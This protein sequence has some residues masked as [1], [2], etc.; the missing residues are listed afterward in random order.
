MKKMATALATVLLTV[1]IG[2]SGCGSTSNNSV[3][4]DTNASTGVEAAGPI[5]A[6]DIKTALGSVDANQLDSIYFADVYASDDG[7]QVTIIGLWELVP[8]HGILDRCA[9]QIDIERDEKTGEAKVKNTDYALEPD[10]GDKEISDELQTALGKPS[11]E[12]YYKDI[13]KQ[14]IDAFSDTL[15]DP[16]SAHYS[17]IR[18]YQSKESGG[19]NDGKFTEGVLVDFDVNAKNRLGGYVG[20]EHYIFTVHDDGSIEQKDREPRYIGFDG[21]SDTFR[22]TF[23]PGDLGLE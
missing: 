2:L 1:A 6:S 16:Y 11:S 9:F 23:E 8:K 4:L 7:M 14:C 22:K 17:S 15:I 20:D 13:A 18:A 19:L 12:S 5:T 3:G 21:L 10:P